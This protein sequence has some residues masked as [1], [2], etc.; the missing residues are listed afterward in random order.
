[1]LTLAETGENLKTPKEATLT[2]GSK[3]TKGLVFSQMHEGGCTSGIKAEGFLCC[4]ENR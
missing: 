4:L 3:N 2:H 1:M